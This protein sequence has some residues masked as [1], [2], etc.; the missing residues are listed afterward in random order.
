MRSTIGE[1]AAC[2]YITS[3][4]APINNDATNESKYYRVAFCMR[5]GDTS[6]KGPS[7]GC[8][9]SVSDRQM[10]TVARL[11]G[12]L[13]LRG[14]KQRGN[15]SASDKTAISSQAQSD[16]ASSESTGGWLQYPTSIAQKITGGVSYAID[17]V[18][19]AYEGDDDFVANLDDTAFDAELDD[20][21]S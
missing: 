5:G 6:G 12:M 17:K 13:L 8:L 15:A 14:A 19:S 2:A 16:Q 7:P 11:S 21:S 18:L 9:I 20:A 1:N 10:E 4:G 3:D